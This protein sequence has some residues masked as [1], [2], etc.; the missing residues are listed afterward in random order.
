[1][2]PRRLGPL[3]LGL[4]RVIESSCYLALLDAHQN[5]D[6]AKLELT[7]AT[8]VLIESL[9]HRRTLPDMGEPMRRV[10]HTLRLLQAATHH[11]EQAKRRR[12]RQER[13]LPPD[14]GLLL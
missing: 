3:D 5:H 6:A 13:I 2:G 11:H 14:Q 7:K 10:K 8:A 9:R 4:L 1:M 12:E